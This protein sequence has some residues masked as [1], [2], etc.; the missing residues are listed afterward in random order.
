MPKKEAT[1]YPFEDYQM[2]KKEAAF[3]LFKEG[4][5]TLSPEVKGF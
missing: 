5:T 2:S 1:Y 3:A 4:K